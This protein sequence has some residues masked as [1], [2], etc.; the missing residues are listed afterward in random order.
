MFRSTLKDETSLKNFVNQ[1]CL[2]IKLYPVIY[3][4]TEL[5][6]VRGGVEF[7]V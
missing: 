7:W 6:V 4:H 3:R 2:K 5:F 1:F